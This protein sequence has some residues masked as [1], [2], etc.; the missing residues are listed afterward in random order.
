MA[1]VTVKQLAFI[2]GL[3]G[4]LV[5]FM[6][7][8][9]PVPT[10]FKIYKRKTSE[11]YQALPYSVGLL[12]ASL[13]LY[14]ALLQSG[15]F[16]ILSINTIGSTIQATY[17][18]LFIIYSPRAGKVATLK[19]I[20]I[21]NVASLGLVLLLTTLFS[22]GKTRIQVVGWISAG[23]NIGTFVAPLSIIKRVIET[24]SVEYMP[25]N[26]SFF[27]TICATMWFFYGIFV[28]DFFIAIPNVVGF[29]FGIAQMFLYIIYKYMMKSD[30]TTLEQL[31][32]TT[33]RPL[34]VPTANH[35]P[36]GQELKAVTITSPRQVDY[37]TEHHPMFMERDE[38]LS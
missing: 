25:F 11:G 35:E 16:L 1:V 38:Y 30:E 8:L 36:S 4:N 34:Y 31:E 17:L 23:V 24:R 7:Y 15:K 12:C 37:F 27:L 2:F 9:S 28:R 10:F 6:V 33:E 32:E 5:S 22:K 26:L 19:M 20:L 14:Y 21:L 29:V 13:F 18:V 3:L